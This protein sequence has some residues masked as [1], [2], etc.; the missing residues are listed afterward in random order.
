MTRASIVDNDDGFT[1]IEMIMAMIVMTVAVVAL[2]AAMSGLISFTQHDKGHAAVE[3]TVQNFGQAV[4]ARVSFH[5]KLQSAISDTATSMT[6]TDGSELP[7]ANFY[8]SVDRETVHVTSRSGNLL[9]GLGRHVGDP[10]SAVAH[11]ANAPVLPEFRCP[12]AADLTPPSYNQFSSA[13][14]ATI[15]RV[16]YWN[17]ETNSFMNQSAC[18][19]YYDSVC[20]Y[21]ATN[22]Q[23]LPDIR[24][25][26]DPG[27]ER[28]T[29]HVTTT[30]DGRL[31]GV[32]TFGQV[33]VRRGSDSIA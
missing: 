14:N 4:E 8:V 9:T 25:E 11:L 19:T 1:L 23:S 5:T 21:V 24:P 17:P 29:I 15:S 26:C 20:T 32:D 12:G 10:T 7:T 33:I 18:G 27:I 13:V 28:L 30:G 31:K 16:D 6:V 3:S 2:V 22:G